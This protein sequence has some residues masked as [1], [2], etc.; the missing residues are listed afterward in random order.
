MAIGGYGLASL[1]QGVLAIALTLELFERTDSSAWAAA[2]AAS[3][4]V[5][6]LVLSPVAGVL[7]DRWGHRRTLQWAAGARGVLA[8]GLAAGIVAQLAPALLVALGVLATATATPVYPALNAL[9]PT[10]VPA[11]A[12]A[13]ANSLLSTVETASWIGGPAIGGL[14]VSMRSPGAA[15]L[16]AAGML[17]AAAAVL[18][19]LHDPAGPSTSQPS[20]RGLRV[21]LAAGVRLLTGST[22]SLAIVLLVVV[23][24]VIDG[25][26]QVLLVLLADERLGMGQGGYGVLS[27]AL[28]LG[29]LSAVVVNRRLAAGDTPLVPLAAAVAAAGLTFAALAVVRTAAPAV[30]LLMICGGAMVVTEVVAITVLQRLVP[31]SHRARVFGLVDAVLIGGLLIGAIVAPILEAAAGLAGALLLVGLVLPACAVVTA[32]LMWRAGRVASRQAADLRP[33]VELLGALPLLRHAPEPVLESLA[34][35]GA[36][37]QVSEGHSILRQGDPAGDVYVVLDGACI[38]MRVHGGD[39]VLAVHRCGP[40]ECFGELGPLAG[41]ARNASV[42]AATDATVL[43]IS[44]AAF[45]VAVNGSAAGSAGSAPAGIVTRVAPSAP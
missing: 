5:P 42:L 41:R 31:A 29:A 36:V 35:A 14:A 28:G 33:L 15:A 26:G 16:L 8:I 37:E 30:G 6:Y 13:A 20:G 9:V 3:R 17:V 2:G 21:E 39:E 43:R 27:A 4:L 10:L 12:L 19:L 34:L 23:T 40:G 1:G 18:L 24:N 25:A 32:P 38:V 11:D 45:V 44:G 7:A 22:S